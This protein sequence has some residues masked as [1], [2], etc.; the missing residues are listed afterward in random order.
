[1][2]LGLG[3]KTAIVTGGSQGIGQDIARALAGEGV[4]VAI[5]ARGEDRLMQSA[6][7]IRAQT[8][9]EVLPVRVDVSNDS[10]VQRLVRTVVDAWGRVDVLV[11]GVADA[12]SAGFMELTDED[13]RHDFDVKFLGYVRT[14][15]HVIPHMKANSWGRIVN[16]SGVAARTAEMGYT[17]GAVNIAVI[18]VTKKLSNELAPFGITVNAIHPGATRTKRREAALERTMSRLN[19]SREEAEREHVA[20]I[21]IGRLIEGQDIADAVLFLASTRASAITGQAL[22]IDGGADRVVRI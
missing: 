17:S 3:G 11:N 1:M 21:P 5:C 6:A 19:V 22:T 4:K 2:D 20:R 10:D 9:S 8:G 14:A 7:D 18:N 12:H 16:L 15:R 13:W